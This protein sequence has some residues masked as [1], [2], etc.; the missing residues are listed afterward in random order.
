MLLHLTCRYKQSPEANKD[1]HPGF[2]NIAA[3]CFSI[4]CIA[5]SSGN[6]L[7]AWSALCYSNLHQAHMSAH[8]TS[9]I[10]CADITVQTWD[11]TIACAQAPLAH[12]MTLMASTTDKL[13]LCKVEGGS[14]TLHT[15]LHDAIKSDSLSGAQPFHRTSKK[16]ALLLGTE[17][18]A[19][20][21]MMLPLLA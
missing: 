9:C 6:V 16:H 10:I 20:C 14:H 7:I 21:R 12:V 18:N 19:A 8:T 15:D 13:S 5:S 17:Y 2:N 1:D 4:S 3:A 11:L